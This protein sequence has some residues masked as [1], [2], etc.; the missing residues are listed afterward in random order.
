MAKPIA[1]ASGLH[2]MHA[3]LPPL[4]RW[5]LYMLL[6]SLA[7]ARVSVLVGPGGCDV[8]DTNCVARNASAAHDIV[9]LEWDSATP[10]VHVRPSLSA[11]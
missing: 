9:V 10:A 7:A 4:V 8:S 11:V 5:T 2:L 3:A 6:V 1:R